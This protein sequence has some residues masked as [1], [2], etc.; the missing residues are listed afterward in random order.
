MAIK[1]SSF[2]ISMTKDWT[3]PT[4]NEFSLEFGCGIIS[5]ED[6]A[7]A[8]FHNGRRKTVI[9]T[10]D[11]LSQRD[12]TSSLND[13]VSPNSSSTMRLSNMAAWKWKLYNALLTAG[14]CTM[15]ISKLQMQIEGCTWSNTSVSV[16]G[17]SIWVIA[18][19]IWKQRASDSLRCMT[20]A[21]L[22]HR[23]HTHTHKKVKQ[24][25]GRELTLP[26]TADLTPLWPSSF[27]DKD[28]EG[29]V[30]ECP[31]CDNDRLKAT[32]RA[33]QNSQDGYEYE[34]SNDELC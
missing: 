20:E 3:N 31:S 2:L 16:W 32:N 26:P 5:T 15:Q 29:S 24:F 4:I 33:T 6:V 12:E 9:C 14:L 17:T 34:N 18:G 23:G 30:R 8:R 11:Y 28:Y 13:P 7:V 19:N 10:R 21:V 25:F 22:C 1:R 27:G